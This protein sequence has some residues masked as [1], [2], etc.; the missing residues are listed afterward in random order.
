MRHPFSEISSQ[1][2]PDIQP[3]FPWYGVRTRSNQERIAASALQRKGY[4]QYV[5]LYRCRRRWSDRI[6]TADVPLFPGYV[7]CRFDHTQRLPIVTTPGV[8]SIIGF[9]NDPA[10]I[11]ESEIQAIETLLKSGLA[12]GPHPFLHEGQRVRIN[13]GSLKDIEGILV[14]KKSD[15]R[16][17]VSVN[18]L[19]RSVCVE[20]DRAWIVTQSGSSP[21][22]AFRHCPGDA[23][24]SPQPTMSLD[25]RSRMISFRLTAD[26]YDKCRELCFAQGL[27]SVSEMARAAINLLLQQPDRLPAGGLGSS[28]CR[29]R[30]PPPHARFGV[31]EI[32]PERRLRIGR[33]ARCRGGPNLQ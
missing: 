18:M 1:P 27:R 6:V 25:P 30:R 28:R 5:P 19:Q 7:F 13:Y 23:R 2:Q 32:E 24:Q 22:T 9:G 21:L 17:V 4:E 33:C 14:K 12:A 8:V 10:P 3:K 31:Q 26:E 29:T 11:P 20:I 16:L 15:W